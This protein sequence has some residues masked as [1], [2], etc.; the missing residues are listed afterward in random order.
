M[1]YNLYHYFECERG[2]FKNLSSVSLEEGEKILRMLRQDK[3]VF[4]SQRSE[5]YL[6]IRRELERKAR[7]LFIRK[8]GQPKKQFPHYMTLGECEWIRGWYKDDC[9]LRIELETFPSEILSFT[10]GDL[11]PTMR[12]KDGKEYREQVY[13]IEEIKKLI[14]RYGLPQQWNSDGRAGPERYIEVQVWDDEVINTYLKE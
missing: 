11:F 14:D 13:T 10:Y 12:Y 1:K 6:M 5:E 4:A 3:D 7:E 9:E 2:P 8:G